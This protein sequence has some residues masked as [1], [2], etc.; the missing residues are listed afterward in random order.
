MENTKD[1]MRECMQ[2]DNKDKHEDRMKILY[3][4]TVNWNWIKQRPHFICEY[5]SKQNI[6]VTYFSITPLFKQKISKHELGKF[7]KI[8]DICVIPYASRFKIIKSINKFFVKLILKQRFDI[9]VLTHPEQIEY[10]PKKLKTNSKIIYECMDNMP[11]F[12]ADKQRETLINKERNLCERV[13]SIITSSIY[14]KEKIKREYNLKSKNITVIKNAVEKSIKSEVS[15]KII[16]KSP[17]MVYIGTISEWLDVEKIIKYAKNNQGHYIYLVGPIESSVKKI[18]E[19]EE[20]IILVGAV[21]HSLVKSYIDAGDVMLIP[22]K[23]NELIKAV[24]PVKIYEYLSLSKIVISSYWEELDCYKS[25]P[26]V[27]F[28]SDFEKFKEAIEEAL[29]ENVKTKIDEEFIYNNKWENRVEEY[30]KVLHK[31]IRSI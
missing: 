29:K 2:K 17:N 16:L 8:K 13:D 30:L 26:L 9:V 21:R 10:L 22:F 28:Y 23:I 7:L 25:N 24:D 11:Y 15:E 12:Y 3:F 5:I 6:E 18:L 20:N 19:K 27:K 31:T 14:L 1:I 4:S